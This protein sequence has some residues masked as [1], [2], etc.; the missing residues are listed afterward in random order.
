MK[1]AASVPCTTALMR[2]SVVHAVPG[3][4]VG[5]RGVGLTAI[6][7]GCGSGVGVTGAAV[8]LLFS[9][10]ELGDGLL[11]SVSLQQSAQWCEAVGSV[12]LT[13][14]CLSYGL[15]LKISKVWRQLCSM[16]PSQHSLNS[17]PSSSSC[18]LC[19]GG[20]QDRLPAAGTAFPVVR[21]CLQ[22]AAVSKISPCSLGAGM[23][24]WC[25]R[26][27]DCHAALPCSGDGLL[28]LIWIQEL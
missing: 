13:A 2:G 15:S 5:H 26:S 23:W 9:T 19:A 10:A 27:L 28:M 22:R 14:L 6:P 1:P 8:Q 20:N 21:H 18:L 11:H 24:R 4:G 25:R 3:K 7:D 12:L 16:G 17:F